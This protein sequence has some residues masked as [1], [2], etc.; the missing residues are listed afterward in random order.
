MDYSSLAE[1]MFSDA[2]LLNTSFF[3]SGFAYFMGAVSKF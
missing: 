2:A 3:N 1:S